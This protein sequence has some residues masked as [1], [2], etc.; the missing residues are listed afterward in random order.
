MADEPGRLLRAH[1]YFPCVEAN[2][3]PPMNLESYL[4]QFELSFLFQGGFGLVRI[5]R[6]NSRYRRCPLADEG[7]ERSDFPSGRRRASD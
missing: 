6:S 4:S 5:D 3:R 1:I 2:A 7:A